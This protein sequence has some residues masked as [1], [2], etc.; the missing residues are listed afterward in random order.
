MAERDWHL[1]HCNSDAW[2]AA[3]NLCE[4]ARRTIAIEQYI[5]QHSGI[6]NRILELLASMARQGVEVRL[7]ADAY[8]S[9]GLYRSTGAKQLRKAGG[10]IAIFNGLKTVVRAPAAAVHRM[11][12]KSI[13]CDGQQLMVGG[14]CFDPRMRDWRDTMLWVKGGVAAVA[15][16]EFEDS[17]QRTTTGR[18]LISKCRKDEVGE[19]G[20]QYL[21]TAPTDPVRREYVQEF[22]RQV[23]RAE[24]SIILTT[25][26]L[27]PGRGDW[28][29]VTAALERAVGRGVDVR[30]MLPARSDQW[31]IDRISRP[32]ARGL[33]DRGVKVRGYKPTMLHAKLAS[34]DGRWSA[35][36]SFN[37]GFD[38]MWMNFESMA[39]TER[40]ALGKALAEQ[41]EADWRVS[42]PTN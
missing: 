37:L 17:W 41:L 38:S 20:W 3:L 10:Q 18:A 36:G 12:R 33:A 16:R 35:I 5:I 8:G 11:H 13:I 19:D 30:L 40:P 27:V 31:W 23:D 26:Y 32:F 28:Q 21:V 6:G 39:V 25:P 4:C 2:E 34:I 29:K 9:H 1:Y 15:L 7:I 14:S 24:S 22:L 42:E